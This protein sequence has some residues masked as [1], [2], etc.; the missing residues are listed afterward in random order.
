MKTKN[1]FFSSL[2]LIAAYSC[3]LENETYDQLGSD[4]VM[5]TENDVKAAVT[6]IYHELRGGGWDRYNCAWGS[7]LTMQI[8]CTDECDCNWVWDK[9][10][11]FL[12]T[13]ETTDLGPIL[14]RTSSRCY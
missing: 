11:D 3:S 9:Q 10:L 2:F 14:Y 7:L 4:N 12:W 6:G 8:G 1:I 5:T 13:A